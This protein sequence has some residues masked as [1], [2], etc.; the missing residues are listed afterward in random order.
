MPV[1][2]ISSLLLEEQASCEVCFLAEG[3][4]SVVGVLFRP[5]TGSGVQVVGG[6]EVDASG[7]A[8]I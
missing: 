6:E 5:G 7:S 8:R 2:L 4:Q 1:G 3:L